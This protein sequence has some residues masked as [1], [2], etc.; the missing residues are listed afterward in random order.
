MIPCGFAGLKKKYITF[1]FSFQIACG[2]KQLEKLEIVHRDL[3]ARN[4]MINEWLQAKV[5]DFG[6]AR[7]EVIF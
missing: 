1:L 3:A 7:L 4:I 2:M 6:L 5:G